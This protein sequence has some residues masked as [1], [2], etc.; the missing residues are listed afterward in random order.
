MNETTRG[1]LRLCEYKWELKA[2][3]D[4][5]RVNGCWWWP[6]WRRFS[7]TEPVFFAYLLACFVSFVLVCVW[8]GVVFAFSVCLGFLVGFLVVWFSVS[9]CLFF[10]FVCSLILLRKRTV[11]LGPWGYS[12][13]SALSLRAMEAKGKP[14][15]PCRPS[16][17]EWNMGNK[18]GATPPAME[19]SLRGH[20]NHPGRGHSCG[21]RTQV[22]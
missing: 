10:A 20:A 6:R 11:T 19:P 8:G 15:V 14:A 1:N 13:V 22:R 2:K 5:D 12:G 3:E 16:T 21:I 9:V 7:S 17:L 4:R 18:T